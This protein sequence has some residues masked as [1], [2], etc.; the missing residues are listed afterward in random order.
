MTKHDAQWEEVLRATLRAQVD[1]ITTVTPWRRPAGAPRWAAQARWW[2]PLT[3][4]A[5]VLL[6]V[7]AAFLTGTTIN[8]APAHRSTTQPTFQLHAPTTAALGLP[9][10]VGPRPP[11]SATATHPVPS[12]ASSVPA[13]RSTSTA[14]NDAI[15][16][17]LCGR[18]QLTVAY[19]SGGEGTGSNFAVLQIVNR[20][21]TAC[22]LRG[23]L[24]VA[25]TSASGATP[26]V[27]PGWRNHVTA[28]GLT[29]A[30]HEHIP[31]RGSASAGGRW[32]ELLLSGNSR[33][34]DAAPNGLC[35]ASKVVAPARWRVT[36]AIDA[37]VPNFDPNPDIQK[38][39]RLTACKLSNGLALESVGFISQP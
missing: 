1:D 9:V 29:L 35:P 22:R 30:A 25:P 24:T 18:T 10:T 23:E 31:A 2:V 13:R 33:D 37:T 36:G 26:T 17:P 20:S 32:A 5:A 15:P 6:V 27:A 39:N 3:A 21:S 34:D 4:A 28:S 7:A 8:S 12:E 16:T 38:L 14:S 11:M 19:R